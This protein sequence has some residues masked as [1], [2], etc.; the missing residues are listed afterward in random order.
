MNLD[1]PLALRARRIHV[2][3]GPGAGKS[4]L[5]RH[6]ASRLGIKPHKLDDIAFDPQTGAARPLCARIRD[7]NSVA[8]KSAWVAEGVYLGWTDQ[9]LAL[10]D[11]IVWLDVPIRVALLRK[12][13]HHLKRSLT[14]GY[15]HAGMHN[16]LAHTLFIWKY[17][18]NSSGEAAASPNDDRLVTRAATARALEPPKDKVVRCQTTD[19]IDVLCNLIE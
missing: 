19:E 11:L 5:A 15:P 1:G 6:L 3:G 18:M 9:L 14:A 17:Y 4:T 16:Q 13:P 7:I 8:A 2:V 10:A 12:I